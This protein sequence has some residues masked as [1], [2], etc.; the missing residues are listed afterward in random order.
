MTYQS[1]LQ[2]LYKEEIVPS[3]MKKFRYKSI[4]E[5]PKLKKI[6]VHQGVGLS[7]IDKKIID[8]SMK[9]ITD[10]TGQ[11]AILCYSKHDESGFKLRKGMP[12]GVKVTLRRIKMFEFLE[13]LI[14]VSLPRVRDFN[15]VKESSFDGYGNY[16]MGIMEQVI[17]PEINIDKIRKNMGM[18]ITF[19]TSAKND[20]EA[21][22]LLSSFGIPFKKK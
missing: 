20:I 11:K 4:M 18:N 21:K 14:V 10:I 6:V 5:V 3:L 8:F 1:R 2:K 19:V 16:N 9:E 13:R 17:Y 12:I 7:V 15:G 22:N